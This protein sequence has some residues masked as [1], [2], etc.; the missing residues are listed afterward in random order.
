[1]N[2]ASLQVLTKSISKLYWISPRLSTIRRKRRWE[3]YLNWDNST[4]SR[5]LYIIWYYLYIRSNSVIYKTPCI[6]TD[7]RGS[8]T[9]KETWYNV[10]TN[11]WSECD[12]NWHTACFELP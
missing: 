9:S 7:P 6:F 11:K 5:R 8:R 2:T 3:S 1:M 10:D 4:K 12:G